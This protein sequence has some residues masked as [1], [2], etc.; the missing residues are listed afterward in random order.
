MPPLVKK[1]FSSYVAR[2]LTSRAAKSFEKNFS[3]LPRAAPFHFL[4]SFLS[5]LEQHLNFSCDVSC[6]NK[7]KKEGWEWNVWQKRKESFFRL[8]FRVFCTSSHR[9]ALGFFLRR[10]RLNE[11]RSSFV[12]FFYYPTLFNSIN[13]NP[14]NFAPCVNYS[15][16]SF[17]C[18]LISFV[19]VWVKGFEAAFL[20]SWR[21]ERNLKFNHFSRLIRRKVCHLV[22]GVFL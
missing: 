19:S 2:S 1:S 5:S 14:N 17:M 16:K 4:I 12:F 6:D 11:N 20:N 15:S 18:I 22:F 10:Q 13:E 8:A 9:Q 3:F 21:K 7:S